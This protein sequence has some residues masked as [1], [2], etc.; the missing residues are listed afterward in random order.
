KEATFDFEIFG[1]D[2][3]DPV[4]VGDAR[5]IVFEIAD[6]NFGG[7]RG[8]EESGRLGFFGAVEAGEHDFVAVGGRSV[9]WNDIEQ[10]AGEARV[11]EMR[12]NASAHG[13]CAE[14]DCL[15]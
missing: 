10:Q 2:F 1:D 7:E 3:D 15:P 6:G 14:N 11:G 4:G 8:G 13:A 12:G 5:E 9:F